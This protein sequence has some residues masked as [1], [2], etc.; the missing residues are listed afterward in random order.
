M[1]RPF[2]DC[3]WTAVGLWMDYIRMLAPYHMLDAFWQ[4]VSLPSATIVQY[5][6]E[7]CIQHQTPLRCV[8]YRERCRFAWPFDAC[9][10]VGVVAIAHSVANCRHH[11]KA[12]AQRRTVYWETSG[13]LDVP[14]AA[15]QRVDAV[16]L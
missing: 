11:V 15:R 4:W 1:T 3:C 8:A 2:L 16:R 13:W 7:S 9:A 12:F 6:M 5:S 14:T 10:E